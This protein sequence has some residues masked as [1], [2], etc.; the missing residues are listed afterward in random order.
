MF[1]MELALLKNREG[2]YPAEFVS[3][4]QMQTQA[5]VS[6]LDST[7]RFGSCGNLSVLLV[8]CPSISRWRPSL[9]SSAFIEC[10]SIR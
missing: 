10:V 6:L 7:S 2:L 1:S 4:M 8:R 5:E 3:Q 9:V